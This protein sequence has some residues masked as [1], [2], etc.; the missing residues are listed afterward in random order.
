MSYYEI[1]GVSSS[2]NISEIRKAYR[3]L[4]LQ[5]HPDK[6]QNNKKEAEE[7]FREISKA[8]EIL[9]DPEKRRIFD[10]S[11]TKGISN[12][13]WTSNFIFRDPTELFNEIFSAFNDINK[14]FSSQTNRSSQQSNFSDFFHTRVFH[15]PRGSSSN[16]DIQF[17][18][19]PINRE[20]TVK[21]KY[22][23]FSTEFLIFPHFYHQTIARIESCKLSTRQKT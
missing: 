20:I 15:T 9:S 16:E 18:D 10:E 12:N 5:W 23:Q 17:P 7:K 13:D 21:M 19:V 14:R 22:L 11:R 8:Y 1:L 4:A 2:A 6:N 3:Q